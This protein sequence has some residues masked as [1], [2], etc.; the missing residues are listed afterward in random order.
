MEENETVLFEAIENSR[1][2]KR[3]SFEIESFRAA[4]Y[5]VGKGSMETTVQDEQRKAIRAMAVEQRWRVAER[6]Y[7][8]AREWKASTLRALHPDWPSDRVNEAVREGFSHARY[9]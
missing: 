6:L 4:E 1:F 3:R 9:Q 8:Q 5:D 7:F 2:H